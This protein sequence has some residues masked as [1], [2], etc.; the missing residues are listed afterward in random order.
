[1]S[2]A[3]RGARE[4][5][6]RTP[7]GPWLVLWSLIVLACG[8]D[9][10]AVRVRDYAVA[11]VSDGDCVAVY[12][13]TLGCCGPGC[14]N[15]TISKTDESRYDMDVNARTPSCSP[16]PPCEAILRGALCD[17][18]LRVACTGGTCALVPM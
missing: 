16:R 10:H 9:D 18:S 14:A 17:R 1:M 7:R 13:G 2:Q 6:G 15:A 4:T 5:N 12:E 3:M 11:C 8:S